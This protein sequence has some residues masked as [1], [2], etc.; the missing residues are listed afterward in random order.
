MLMKSAPDFTG[1]CLERTQDEVGVISTGITTGYIKLKLHL[2][3]CSR[4]IQF[5]IICRNLILFRLSIPTTPKHTSTNPSDS[6]HRRMK[7]GRKY[8]L[9]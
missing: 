4:K 6:M 8:C 1:K 9:C 7:L 2:D 3:F 5:D